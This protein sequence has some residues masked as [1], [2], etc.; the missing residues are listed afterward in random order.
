MS[1]R[2]SEWLS[3]MQREYLSRFVP[4]GGSAVKFV[5]GIDDTIADVRNRLSSAAQGRRLQFVEI[6]TTIT[7]LHMIQDVFFA[8]AKDIDWDV[9]AQRWVEVVFRKNEYE[10]PRPGKHAPLREVAAA[11]RLDETLLSRQVYQWLSNGIM[12][13]REMAQDFR[14]AMTNLCMRRMEIADQRTVAPVLEWL[15][16]ELRAI[17]AVRQVPIN[18]RITRHNGRAMLRSLCHWLRLSGGPGLAVVLDIRQL[19]RT[20]SIPEGQLRYSAAAVLDAFEVLRQLID[21]AESFEGLF[22]GIVA[23][24]AFTEDNPKRSIS[25]YTALKERIW[26]DVHARGHENPLAPL[27]V[28]E[29]KPDASEHTLQEGNELPFVEERVAIEALR[30]GVPNTA[31][32]RLLGTDER[33]LCNRFEE[34]LDQCK[35]GLLN[36]QMAEGELIAGGF[37]SGKSHL[38]GYLADIALRQNFIVSRIAISKETPLFDPDRLFASAIRYALVPGVNDDAM[39]AAVSRL[40]PNG[41]S[42]LET[43]ATEKG[44][45]LFAALAFVLPKQVITTEDVATIARFFAGSR[46]SASRVRQWLRA[47]GALQLFD[48]RGIKAAQLAFQR[49]HFTPHLFRAAGFSGWCVLIDE[50]ELVGRYSSLQ[51]AKSYAE[52]CRWLGLNV[53][54]GVP[55]VLGVG[56]ITD[57]FKAAVL[58]GRLDEEKI[59]RVLEAKGLTAQARFASA[60]MRAIESCRNY[61]APPGEARLHASIDRVRE[62]YRKAYGWMPPNPDVG[63]QRVGK[64]MRQ[65]IKSWIQRLYGARAEIDIES[66]PADYS[67]N[68]DLEQMPQPEAAEEDAV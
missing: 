67:E 6:D 23:G 17:G 52:L 55:G 24:P 42:D 2:T 22:V 51:R 38:L 46:I 15:R 19:S 13:D 10:W 7:R 64:T 28:L 12:R 57:D 21:D 40:D 25:A 5:V 1:V 37:G 26:A 14:A 20:D 65:Y 34:R 33:E 39:T 66:V 29:T 31:A 3:L 48:L 60:G 8:I 59:P 58:D 68:K 50:V 9:L 11:N 36:G 63:E 4:S 56:A 44:W 45:P 30:A 47:A 43:L 18:S 62:L 41:I 53:N 32:I 35:S 61:L 16:G 54:V 27:L 49:I